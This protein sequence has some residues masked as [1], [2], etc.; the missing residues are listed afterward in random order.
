MGSGSESVCEKLRK[1]GEDEGKLEIIFWGFGKWSLPPFLLP[2][3]SLFPCFPGFPFFSPF[4]SHFLSIFWLN[5]PWIHPFFHP[6]ISVE[7]MP[8][9]PSVW[10][11]GLRLWPMRWC[12]LAEIPRPFLILPGA[13]NT[14]S[15]KSIWWIWRDLRESK[16]QKQREIG[17]KKVMITLESESWLK[18][19]EEFGFLSL[20]KLIHKKINSPSFIS[21]FY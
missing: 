1:I 8:F 18:K 2:F 5:F 4:S 3:P 20:V 7:V 17:S 16:G 12:H 11:R 14:C 9:S 13:R 6:K 19:W 10:S 15:L 21:L